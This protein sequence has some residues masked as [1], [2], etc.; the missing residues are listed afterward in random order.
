MTSYPTEFLNSLE[1]SGLPSLKLRLKV[2]VP[3]MLMRNL[4]PPRLCNGTR[5]QVTYLGRNVIKA[6]IMTGMAKG[7]TVIIPRIP[8]IPTDL[9]FQFQKEFSFR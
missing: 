6:V 2:G 9:P 7:E 1:L 3:V 5:L 4:D 8:I